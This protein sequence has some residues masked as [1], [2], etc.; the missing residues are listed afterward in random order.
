MTSKQS[1]GML[2]GLT[3]GLTFAIVF[4]GIDAYQLYQAHIAYPWAAF[5]PGLVIALL[6]G[7]FVGW[8]TIRTENVF[9]GAISWL[10]M[11]LLIAWLG[12]WLPLKFTP[13]LITSLEPTLKGW[14]A[15]PVYENE[16]AI[17]GIIIII[18]GV[19]ALILGALENNLVEQAFYSPAAGAIVVPMFFVAVFLSVASLGADFMLNS[20]YRGAVIALDN[21]LQF[22]VDN[23]GKQIDPALARSK[24]LG[25]LGSIADQINQ[26]RRLFIF[27]YS[28]TADEVRIL[29]DFKTS[30][31]LCYVIA[32]Q[33]SYCKI[34]QPPN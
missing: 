25:A 14:L 12:I 19:P 20:P 22:A 11:G 27:Y 16:N 7:G 17:L 30:W 28:E 6:V 18:L 5:G 9:I 23:Q 33:P 1:F 29:I 8:I 4:W 3:A 32:E 34:I 2:Y 24:H 21:L 15:Y 31:A 13:Q 10:G 26:P